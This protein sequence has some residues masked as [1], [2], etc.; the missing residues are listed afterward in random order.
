M[1]N[2]LPTPGPNGQPAGKSEDPVD[3]LIIIAISIWFLSAI[4]MYI[5]QKLVPNW[6]ETPIRYLRLI[7]NLFISLVPIMMALTVKDKDLKIVAL[8]IGICITIF[9]FYSNFSWIFR[10]LM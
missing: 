5:I 4:G 10:S 9:L 3:I 6:Y 1:E 7:L 2:H 8:I